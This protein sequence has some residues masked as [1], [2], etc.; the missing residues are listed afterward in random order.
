VN[1]ALGGEAATAYSRLVLQATSN[2]VV[3]ESLAA[4]LP[5][6]LAAIPQADRARFC[7]MIQ[8]VLKQRPEAALLVAQSLPELLSV[9][10]DEGLAF[11]VAEA[12]QKHVDS[13][14]EAEGFLRMESRSGQSVLAEVQG[15]VTLRSMHRA[16]SLYARA[17]CGKAVSVRQSDTHAFTDGRHVYLPHRIDQYEDDRDAEAYWVLTALAAGF[18]EFGSLDID[19]DSVEGPWPSPR[20]DEMAFDRMVRGFDNGS[21]ARALFLIFERRR[22]EL[23]VC[24]AY[25]GVVRRM[26]NLEPFQ[27]GVQ[28][29]GTS[30]VDRVLKAI[31]RGLRG[32]PCSDPIAADVLKAQDPD[33]WVSVNQSVSAML[34]AYP[35]IRALLSDADE[36]ISVPSVGLEP[37]ALS[38]DD[39]AIESRAAELL[40]TLE[41]GSEW[42]DIRKQVQSQ[43]TD[44]LSYAEMS[45]WLDKLDAPSGPMQ[46][47]DDV[48]SGSTQRII[49][50]NVD[51]E[52]GVKQARYP[53]WDEG[54]GDYKPDWVCVSEYR[55]QAGASDFVDDVLAEH[56]AM[57]ER[58][59]RTFEALRPQAMRPKRGL[60]DGDTL[61]MD[62]VVSARVAHRAGVPGPIGLY[63]S[64][65]PNSRDVS[66]AFLVDMS[67]ST[68]E[69]INT[70]GKRIID[71]EREALV[72]TAEAIHA[73]GDTMAIYGYSGFGRDQVA[74]YVAK[75]FGEPWGPQIRE[76]IGRMGWKLENRDGAAIRHA[77][78]KL[79]TAPGRERLLILLSDGKPLDGGCNRY[80]DAYS[81]EDTRMALLEAR[82]AGIHPFCI[83]VDP[84]GRGYLR[85]M[86]GDGGYTIIDS[87][88]ALPQRL[89]G[90]YRRLTR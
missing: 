31:D 82:Q 10:D 3:A 37:E 76:R 77:V 64:R 29:Y 1:E 20:P 6:L 72:V 83:T 26:R 34:Q 52:G 18:I 79:K 57:I 42:D 58:L 22:I 17:H 30:A 67:S 25:P 61:D 49:R 50:E 65:R 46:A 24:G 53:E 70:A 36:S 12:L 28:D 74:F 7:S 44:G 54:L 13:A 86:Y 75:E 11:F 38:D 85:Q 45:D 73:L 41:D 84:H 4:T 88:E 89:P 33:R 27:W 23:A 81:Q 55:L 51:F 15:G 63:R 87:V 47:D 14:R 16:L 60:S 19:L 48:E 90:L 68:N 8:G 56:G 66:V 43:D 80:H 21:I 78:A 35:P 5:D 40:R 71:V 69:H 62:A 9:M 39:K 2:P 32:E 59:R